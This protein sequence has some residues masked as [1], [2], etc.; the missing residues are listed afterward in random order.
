MTGGT[1]LTDSGHVVGTQGY[2]APE[3]LRGEPASTR[4]N[5]YAFALVVRTMLSSAMPSLASRV[6][7]VFAR[8][9]NPEP[10]SRFDSATQFIDALALAVP[11]TSSSVRAMRIR[12]RRWLGAIVT[13][14]ALA[15]A[16]AAVW[17]P[18]SATATI[19]PASQVLLTDLVN[20]TSD[21]ELDGAGEILR[22]QLAQSTHFELLEPERVQ[23]ALTR[24]GRR[25]AG[26]R[27]PD[28]AREIALRE[29][30]PVVVYAALTRLGSDYTLTVKLEHV[31]PRP[32]FARR[33]WTRTFV[34]PT[35]AG[36]FETVHGAAVWIRHMAGELQDALDSRTARRPRRRPRRGRRCGSSRRQRTS[37]RLDVCTM[38][39]WCWSRR[40]ASIRS[41]PW[42]TPAWVTI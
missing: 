23:A 33:S 24:M 40:F 39:H 36:L 42:P 13:A 2:L 10:A 26:T 32:S 5:L 27:S 9:L 17:S 25:D 14:A 37:R 8:A 6:E 29:G 21:P 12:R 1:A 7:A 16:T 3:L 15:A 30:V 35:K 28:V 11:S 18:R 19:P 41:S 38:R 34:A 20:G 31:G 22:S 4:S